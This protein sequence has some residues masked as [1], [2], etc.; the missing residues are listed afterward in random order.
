MYV[1]TFSE[2]EGFPNVRPIWRSLTHGV[3][4]S[5]KLRPKM[6]VIEAHIFW[7]C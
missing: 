1:A 4:P 3:D 2:T 5:S 7:A 6:W